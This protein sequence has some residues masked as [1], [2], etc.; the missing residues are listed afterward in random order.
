VGRYVAEQTW[1]G[2]GAFGEHCPFPS[3]DYAACQ[4]RNFKRALDDKAGELIDTVTDG[5]WRE[6]QAVRTQA[7]EA[8]GLQA[9]GNPKTAISTNT[10]APSSTLPSFLRNATRF[11][12]GGK[13]GGSASEGARGPITTETSGISPVMMAGGLA[14]AALIAIMVLKKK[15]R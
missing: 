12:K 15:K 13:A 6:S 7:A 4:A 14:V 2:L 10:P 1:N 11:S 5:K 8:L 3:W 9:K